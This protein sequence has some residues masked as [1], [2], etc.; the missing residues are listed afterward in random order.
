MNRFLLPIAALISGS[1]IAQ[2]EPPAGWKPSSEDI[3]RAIEAFLHDRHGMSGE[4]KSFVER[5]ESEHDILK[6]ELESRLLAAAADENGDAYGRRN[7]ISLFCEITDPESL[8]RLSPILDSDDETLR[9]TAQSAILES[10]PTMEEKLAFADRILSGL[11]K[12]PEHQRDAVRLRGLFSGI[13]HSSRLPEEDRKAILSFYRRV[14]TNAG[15]AIG[16]LS[17]VDLLDRYD[18]EWKKDSAERIRILEE[19]KD[20][21]SLTKFMSDWLQRQ[22]SDLDR[23]AAEETAEPPK[24]PCTSERPTLQRTEDESEAPALADPSDGSDADDIRES[25]P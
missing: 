20:D 7:A 2:D 17:A 1:V 15:F 6:A 13:L 21:S 24:V 11:T 14:A 16:A 25:N 19:W 9:L 10:L 18:E 3:S 5:L 8:A 22:F 12:R 4:F 23:K